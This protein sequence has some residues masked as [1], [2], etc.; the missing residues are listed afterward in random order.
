MD[1]FHRNPAAAAHDLLSTR[2]RWGVVLVLAGYAALCHFN[3]VAIAVA[4][5]EVFIPTI[6]ISEE[7]MGKVYSAFLGIYT[8]G[9]I[10][11]G[12]LIDRIGA[13]RALSLLGLSMGA[14]VA[15]TGSLA[16]LA[17]NANSLWIG[18]ILIRSVAGISNVPLH[19]GAAHV[20]SDILPHR[21]RASANGV[22]T[23]GALVG[24]ACSFPIF[25]WVMDQ[26]GWPRAF[27]ACGMVLFAYGVMWRLAFQ[28]RLPGPSPVTTST[29]VDLSAAPSLLRNLDLWLVTLSYAAYGYFQYLF[30]YWTNYYFEHVLHVSKIDA[31]QIAFFVTL[32][33]GFGMAFG[34]VA[35]DILCR[36]F[37]IPAGR[38]TIVV[39][40]MGLACAFGLAGVYVTGQESAAWCMALAMGALGMCEGVFWTTATDIGRRQRG[41]SAAFMNTGGNAG[42]IF[43]PALTPL[44]ANAVGWNGAIVVACAIAALGGALWFVIKIP[45]HHE[46]H[47]GQAF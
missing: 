34:G 35:T 17:A 24:V 23:A 46:P 12:W 2:A 11:G 38:R 41:F 10:P 8:I 47:H 43:S 9:M 3:R 39:V 7:Q 40:G 31:R 37:G 19:P 4:G 32:A 36:R 27:A 14:M 16:P 28:P 22:V 18:L 30:F 6:H 13:A 26:L 33:Q 15:L 45:P 29:S 20:V 5:A 1:Q 21:S 44:I 42:G 25:G